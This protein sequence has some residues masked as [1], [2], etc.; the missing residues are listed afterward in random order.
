MEGPKFTIQETLSKSKERLIPG[1]GYYDPN[2]KA[3][4]DKVKAF[5]ISQSGKKSQGKRSDNVP[6]PGSYNV[7]KRFGTDAPKYSM[8]SKSKVR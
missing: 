3:I 7:D 8:V 4:H 6:A 5:K 1:P 2:D